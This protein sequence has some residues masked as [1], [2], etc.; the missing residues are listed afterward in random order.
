MTDILILLFIPATGIAFALASV[1][2]IKFWAGDSSLKGRIVGSV[3]GGGLGPGLLLATVIFLDGVN[4]AAAAAMIFAVVLVP[5][6][7]VCW[8]ICYFATR[9]L[10]KLT[11]NSASVFE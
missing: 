10:D 7:F 11:E 5:L 9:K 3:F 4:D 2:L 1:L 8:P 6:A